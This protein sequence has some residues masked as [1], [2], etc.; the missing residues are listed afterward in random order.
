VQ[1]RT[2]EMHAQAELGVAAHWKYKE[3]RGHSKGGDAAME[4]RIAW[5]RQLLEG[6]ARRRRRACCANSTANSPKTASTSSP[7]AAK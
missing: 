3:G 7:R 5:M 4:K 1:I 6:R 2:H